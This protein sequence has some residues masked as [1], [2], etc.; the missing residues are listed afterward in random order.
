[1]NAA[2]GSLH[3]ASTGD[4][5]WT[6]TRSEDERL[7]AAS[8]NAGQGDSES[9]ISTTV[10]VED[11]ASLSFRWD[12][13]AEELRRCPVPGGRRPSCPAVFRNLRYI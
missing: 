5:P 12:V 1:M 6:V 7:C 10:T 13:S 2:G 4:Y 11:G 3:F 8:G 9:V